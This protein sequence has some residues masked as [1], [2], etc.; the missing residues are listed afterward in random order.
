MLTV[1][2]REERVGDEA[3]GLGP[4][5]AVVYS[6]VGRRRGGQHLAL[7]LQ[8]RVRLHHRHGEVPG[9]VR[10]HP[11]MPHQSVPVGFPSETP[12]QRPIT[13]LQHL[14]T[15]PP[16]LLPLQPINNLSVLKKA[17]R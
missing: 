14:L 8:H 6:H 9:R 15:L 4:A 2:E 1:D 17:N 13:H 10:P 7:V 5:V 16:T 12:L 11:N 3:G